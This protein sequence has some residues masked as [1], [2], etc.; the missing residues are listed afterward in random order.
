MKLNWDNPVF[1]YIQTV[2]S[3]AALNLVFLLTCL[4]V[5]TIGPAIAALYQVTLREAR[6][7]YGYLVRPYLRYFR[8]MLGKGILLFLYYGGIACAGGFAFFFW[9]SY[10]GVG[11]TAAA[12]FIGILLLFLLSPSLWAFP[13]AARFRDGTVRILKNASGLV[14]LQPVYTVLLLA[15]DAA[16]AA[17]AVFFPA[18]RIFMLCIGFSFL[19]Y[20]KSLIL[21]RVFETYEEKEENPQ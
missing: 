9:R 19:A 16:G 21:T 18:F 11:G 12:A 17:L 6:K 5:I 7:E 10:G 2:F 15:V 20:A 1:D 3:F 14:I 13:L 8:E 4:P